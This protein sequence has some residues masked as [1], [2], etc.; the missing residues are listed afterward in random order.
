MSAVSVE[1]LACYGPVD[2]LLQQLDGEYGTWSNSHFERKVPIT[3]PLPGGQAGAVAGYPKKFFYLSA[4][5]KK[6]QN[7]DSKIRIWLDVACRLIEHSRSYDRM[8][9]HGSLMLARKAGPTSYRVRYSGCNA[10]LTP[11]LYCVVL[12]FICVLL[13]RLE[14][15]HTDWT[16]HRGARYREAGPILAIPV[17]LQ[18]VHQVL[19]NELGVQVNLQVLRAVCFLPFALIDKCTLLYS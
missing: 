6:Y 2:R 18:T 3:G 1:K 8:I 17:L 11:L 9:N 16:Q 10:V 4:V 12:Y 14:K 7:R 13:F 15:E 5:Y 19:D